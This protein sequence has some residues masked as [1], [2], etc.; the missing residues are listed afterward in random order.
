MKA[1]TSTEFVILTTFMLLV[2]LVFLLLIQAKMS[3][4]MAEKNDILAQNIMDKVIGE[5]R[6]AESVSDG[7]ERTFN[8]PVFLEN[9][10]PYKISINIYPIQG[11][12]IVMTYENKEKI[13]FFDSYMSSASNIDLGN[14]LIRKTNGIIT[15]QKI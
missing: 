6:L 2:F 7:Y 8:L 15:I 14:N 11:G 5:I 1:Q 4:S 3:Q 9:G 12:E 10:I 13:Y